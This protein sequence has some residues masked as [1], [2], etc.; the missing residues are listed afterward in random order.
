MEGPGFPVAY[1]TTEFRQGSVRSPSARLSSHAHR[2]GRECWTIE[3][4]EL[5]LN[6]LA[7]AGT[8]VVL[9]ASQIT[10]ATAIARIPTAS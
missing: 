4:A 7:D 2:G 8:V 3:P 10:L 5:K 6:V 1:R 9:S